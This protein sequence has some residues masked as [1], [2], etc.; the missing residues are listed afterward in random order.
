MA[1]KTTGTDRGSLIALRLAYYGEVIVAL[2]ALPAR[3]FAPPRPLLAGIGLL[4]MLVGLIL[5]MAAGR[6]L[7]KWWSLR[8]E[9]KDGQ[10]LITG[11]VYR[12]M[13]HPSYLGMLLVCLG[14]P[15][16]FQS[17]WAA[18]VMGLGVWPA[19]GHRI[20]VE[21]ELLA[22]HYGDE[23][24]EYARRTARLIPGVF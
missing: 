23:Y 16:A 7:G 19:V 12:F 15:I 21:E 1:E 22:R 3:G 2:L 5:R 18:V 4:L 11:G 14:I 6:A 9:V 17:M 10:P 20:Q 8:A 24:Q 13:R